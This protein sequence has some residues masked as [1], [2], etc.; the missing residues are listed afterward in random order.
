MSLP[1]S[2]GRSD[3]PIIQPTRTPGCPELGP[4]AVMVSTRVDL[5]AIQAQTA[6]VK[7]S[8]SPLMSRL[9]ISGDGDHR[10][11]VAGPM[12]GAPYAVALMETLVAWGARTLLFFGWCGA[13]SP[14]VNIGDIVVPSGAI[15]DEG[16]S[17]HYGSA[18][19]QVSESSAD[20][21][22]QIKQILS[23]QGLSYREGLVWSTDAP[24]RET[25]EKVAA[26]RDQGACAVEME[27]SA[28]FTVGRHRQVSVGAVLTVSDDLST[29]TWK[30]G[31]KDERFRTARR[32][33]CQGLAEFCR[34]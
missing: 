10:I 30:P 33:V 7:A 2:P 13:V 1:P 24:F 17:L 8:R 11:S 18:M 16:T 21:V 3:T 26:A 29:L 27:T 31:F 23:G 15:V 6:F 12:M 22:K 9:F 34:A 5:K 25:P 32:A 20:A 28:L 19:G 14:E 4:L